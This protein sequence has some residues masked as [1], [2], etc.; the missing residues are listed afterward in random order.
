M[1]EKKLA[2]N[3]KRS[4]QKMTE[5]LAIEKRNRSQQKKKAR[6]KSE[7]PTGKKKK[8]KKKQDCGK[9]K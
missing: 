9:R 4:W 7:I 5:I 3:E 2:A 8:R 6:D 1:K